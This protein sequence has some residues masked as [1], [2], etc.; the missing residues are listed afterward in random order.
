MY[1]IYITD[2]GYVRE[3]LGEQLI[4]YR[5]KYKITQVELAEILGITQASISRIESGIQTSARTEHNIL[6]KM[7]EIKH[8]K[9]KENE[10]SGLKYKNV[11]KD[12]K[13]KDFTISYLLRSE[14]G[15]GGDYCNVVGYDRPTGMINFSI[16]DA[17]GHGSTAKHMAS[18]LEFG[19]I[20]ILST[21]HPDL[22]TAQNI[23]RLLSKA[24]MIGSSIFSGPP[25]VTLGTL[26]LHNGKVE[27]INAGNPPILHF[28]RDGEYKKID[29]KPLRPALQL[30]YL[31]PPC[32]PLTI[33]LSE[34]ESLVLL[35]DGLLQLQN[36]KSH[37]S[38]FTRRFKGDSKTICSRFA[39]TLSTSENLSDDTTVL[40]I[41][42]RGG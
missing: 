12:L 7:K 32:E 19:Y 38:K 36:Y 8:P 9:R 26:H 41:T 31:L 18:A 13:L 10:K 24:I 33:Q 14:L 1:I 22:K 6:S 27:I 16:G 23:E 42:R 28:H 11:Q 40:V 39:D 3:S 29:H 34:G 21:L 25:S 2:G 4:E 35:T 20:S 5:S 17:V 37:L 15:G 30:K